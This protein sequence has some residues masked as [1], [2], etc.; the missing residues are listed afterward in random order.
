[1][2]TLIIRIVLLG[3]SVVVLRYATIPPNPTPIQ[4]RPLPNAPF[5]HKREWLMVRLTPMLVSF[6]RKL[7]YISTICECLFILRSRYPLF[8]NFLPQIWM[9]GEVSLTSTMEMTR[10]VTLFS[11]VA[12]LYMRLRCQNLLGGSF[13]WHIAGLGEPDE[14]LRAERP[15]KLITTGPYAYIRH[16]S[17]AGALHG[18][19]A[20]TVYYLLPGSWLRE[21]GALYTW[22][23]MSAVGSC[24]GIW[25]LFAISFIV[26]RLDIEEKVL[27]QQFGE[28]WERWS[29]RVKWRIAPGV[30]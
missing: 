14:K 3:L 27:K 17:Y 28:E 13:K 29:E 30:W 23:G 7:V 20:L 19:I 5:A 25:T 4:P 15:S 6:T 2:F 11:G 16:P 21:S 24:V 12:A 18:Y 22:M 26:L 8:P 10:L 1:M 9:H